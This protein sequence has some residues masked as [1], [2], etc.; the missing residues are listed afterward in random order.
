MYFPISI[1]ITSVWFWFWFRD[2]LKVLN[3]LCCIL[4]V[5]LYLNQYRFAS[6][7]QLDLR[8]RSHFS[9]HMFGQV[10]WWA[11]FNV[12]LHWLMWETCLSTIRSKGK[13]FLVCILWWPQS[14]SFFFF[15]F[16]CHNKPYSDVRPQWKLC[17]HRSTIKAKCHLTL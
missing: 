11:S 15:V 8:E 5:N 10:W 17:S 4:G 7:T 14:W 12:R 1:I 9:L 16:F 6:I 3:I 2:Y 13:S